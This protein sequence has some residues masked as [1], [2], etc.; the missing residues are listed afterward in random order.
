MSYRITLA[1]VLLAA[2]ALTATAS[3]HS[4]NAATNY[5]AKPIKVIV[6]F[7]PGGAPDILGRIIADRLTATW[8]QPVLVENKPGA[9]GNIGSD[10]V[11]KAAPDGYTLVVGTVG[12]HSINGALYQ[13][14]P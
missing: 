9:G 1:H 2:A 12:T 4:Q 14:M 7:T 10:I 5:P 13:K 11:A 3:A 8:G 6:T